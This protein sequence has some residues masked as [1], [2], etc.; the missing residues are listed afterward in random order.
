M[1]KHRH[2]MTLA[3][4]RQARVRARISGTAARPRVTVFRSNRFVY[5]QAINDE[6]GLVLASASDRTLRGALKK[7]ETLTK[8]A[9]ASKAAESLAES[10]KKQK[11]GAAVLD[12]GSYRYHGRVQAVADALRTQGIQV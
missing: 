2:T 3:Q 6:T 9:A 5:L 1:N 11:V 8:T 4:K 7:G 10:L 12:R